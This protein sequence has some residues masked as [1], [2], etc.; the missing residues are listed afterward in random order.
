MLKFLIAIIVFL[1]IVM[2]NLFK[3]GNNICDI[4]DDVYIQREFIKNRPHKPLYQP[5]ANRKFIYLSFDDGPLNGSQNVNSLSLKYK[6]Y[7]S[8]F[9]VGEHLLISN[10]YKR[11]LNNYI[12]NPFI[13][14]SNHSY[15][16]ANNQYSKFYSN[17]KGVLEDFNKS[18]N[19]L[20][21]DNKII[22][23]PGRNI[24]AFDNRTQNISKTKDTV[25]LL[26][27]NGFKLIGWDIEWRYDPITKKPIGTAQEFFKKLVKRIKHNQELVTPSNIVVLLHDP[28]FRKKCKAKELENL[29]TLIKANKNYVLVPLSRYPII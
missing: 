29:I 22:R 2:I 24:W 7:M 27:N 9:I 13:E 25:N 1:S 8:V 19:L 4:D 16:H 15:S 26:T 11:Y 10:N 3:D 5:S 12:Q 17:P 18:M 14:V 21:L 28:M 23:L 20:G 6:A